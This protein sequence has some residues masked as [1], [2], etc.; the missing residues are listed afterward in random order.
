MAE[1]NTAE[2]MTPFRRL[3]VMVPTLLST[4][5]FVLNQTNVVVALPHM[6]GSFSATRDQI[7]W[8]LTSYLVAMAI[9]TAAAGW[10]STRFGRKRVFLIS[11]AGF[12][13]TSFLCAY[14]PSLEI[15]VALRL[16][17]G[18]FGGPIMPITQA[19]MLDIYPRER[20]GTALGIWGIGITIGPVLG[21]IIGGV[22][23]D[24]YGWPWLFFF[25]VPFAAIAFL[26]VF[27]FV[28][29]PKAETGRSLDWIG[30]G[31]LSVAIVGIQLV[32]NRGQSLDWYDSTE[33]ILETAMAAL[34]L[35]ILVVRT[36]TAPGG[37]LS[38][39]MFMDKNFVLGLIFI[40]FWGM[41]VHS[42]L[43]ILSLR[44]QSVDELPVSFVG[45]LM[46]PRGLG[47]I[48][49]ML[50]VGR[51]LARFNPKALAVFGFVMIAFSSW[52]MQGW[53]MH[54]NLRE[55]AVAGFLMGT[56]VALAYVSL[57]VMAMATLPAKIRVEG[58]SLY[59][60]MLNMGSGMGIAIAVIVLSQNI[61]IHHEI[62]SANVSKF[63]QMFR[64][65]L[66]PHA[67]SFGSKSGLTAVE[68][69]V[70]AQ[71]SALAFNQTF[72]LMAFNAVAI[73]PFVY[74]LRRPPRAGRKV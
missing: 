67:W 8:V 65:H 38:P 69:E 44:L 46:S 2:S 14:A 25:N 58:V 56:G 3:L 10:F 9:M 49:A 62:L 24:D 27:L 7:T 39:R 59:S 12:G 52:I 4:T 63:S 23:T 66:L 21:P 47:G 74:L 57:T 30:F 50:L 43:V 18:L 5:L 42:P 11:L 19:I 60:L 73:I 15:A 55:V 22:L 29:K 45:L 34:A 31:A 20:S 6:Q 64:D 26:G 36:V 51:M 40:F 71:A 1:A 54:A 35:Y 37:F 33:V 28:P 61:Q 48:L 13:V 53:A 68:K 70:L 32:L 16:L 72:R 41:A 17:Q